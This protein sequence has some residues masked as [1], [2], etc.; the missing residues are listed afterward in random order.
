MRPTARITWACIWVCNG[1]TRSTVARQLVGPFSPCGCFDAERSPY[2]NSKLSGYLDADQTQGDIAAAYPPSIDPAKLEAQ[3]RLEKIADAN[4]RSMG[5][6][7][8]INRPPFNERWVQLKA[9]EEGTLY[10]ML[11]PMVV[12]RLPEP[13][14]I[15]E[16]MTDVEI[17]P[18][19]LLPTGTEID[20]DP[21]LRTTKILGRRAPHLTHS[22]HACPHCTRMPDRLRPT[23][24][25]CSPW[26]ACAC[27]P[28]TLCH[29]HFKPSPEGEDDDGGSLYYPAVENGGDV[30]GI[31]AM[32]TEVIAAARVRFRVRVRVRV[33]RR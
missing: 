24:P 14:V 18:D 6:G 28:A 15:H 17:G 8:A 29:A 7:G 5:K 16:G 25:P 22:A 26:P 31:A 23:P 33:R 30:A 1:S 21:K 3:R 12:D 2:P 27:G 11:P 9:P 10:A 32:E 13:E 19:Q 20:D 4:K